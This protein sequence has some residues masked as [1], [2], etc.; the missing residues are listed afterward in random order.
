[1]KL[2]FSTI[3]AVA[4]FA[5]SPAPTFRVSVLTRAQMNLIGLS[6]FAPTTTGDKVDVL[7]T[8]MEA[9]TYRVSVVT[10]S[11]AIQRQIVERPTVQPCPTCE[12]YNPLAQFWVDGGVGRVIVEPLIA[13]VPAVQQ[14]P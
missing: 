13:G 14:M 9:E 5:Q 1:M 12:R 6:A 10:H 8:S 11:G 4:A 3:L 7:I 2:L